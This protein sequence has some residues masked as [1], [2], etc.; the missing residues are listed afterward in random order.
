MTRNTFLFAGNFPT[1]TDDEINSAYEFVSVMFSGVLSLWG[2]LSAEIR[3]KKR[4]LCMN[5]LVAWYLLD[6]K[7]QSASGVLGNGG[8]AVS[9]KS[10]GGTSLSF[11]GM[12]AQE[13][14]KQL[15]SNVFGQKALI[16]IQGAPE[17]FGIYA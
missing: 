4:T 6:T 8:M 9:S 16:M 14:I 13:G 1:L 12:D 5:L 3:E 10:I 11:E 15:N 7:P 2:V 17:R